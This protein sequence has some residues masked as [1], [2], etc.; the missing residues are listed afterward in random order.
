M[1]AVSPADLPIPNVFNPVLDFLQENLPSPF[2]AVIFSVLSNVLAIITALYTLILSLLSTNPSNWD[3]QV[4]LPPVIALLTAYLALV[5]L[6]RTTT[7]FLRT[8]FWF[9]KWGVILGAL[10]AACGWVVGTTSRNDATGRSS[11][12]EAISGLVVD[13]IDDRSGGKNPKWVKTEM[14]QRRR[15]WDSFNRQQENA[16][17]QHPSSL[18]ALIATIFMDNEAI[19]SRWWEVAKDLFKVKDS[20]GRREG[21]TRSTTT[22]R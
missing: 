13:L 10:I 21:K 12:A 1:A 15:A 14:K 18:E 19:S 3:V 17:N 5:G 7:W 20:N 9:M 16:Q 6:Y 11:V 8:T 2:Y 4:I 22:S